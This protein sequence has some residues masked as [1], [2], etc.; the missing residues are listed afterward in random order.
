MHTYVNFAG[1]CA[2]ALRFYEKHLGGSI[3]MMMTHGQVPDQSQI[4]P[5]W[6]DAILH[7]R[8]AIGGTELMCADIP[9]A[10]PMRSAYPVAKRRERC[11]SR[12]DLRG[13]RGR[14][15]GVH[16]HAGDI[17][18]LAVR[19]AVRPIWHQLDDRA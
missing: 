8:I 12:A 19:S 14:R 2:E 16:G 1:R 10:E 5:E 7:A 3:E 13:A 9:N 18:R 4:G 15:R 17:L 6:K 11:R